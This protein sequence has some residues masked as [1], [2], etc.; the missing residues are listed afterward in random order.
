MANRQAQRIDRARIR[1]IIVDDEPLARQRL[2]S[3]LAAHDDFDLIAEC[4]DG[5]QAVETIRVERPDLVFLDIRMPGLDGFGV[6]DACEAAGVPVP[7]VVFVTAYSEYALR[8]FEVH[9]FD[10]LLKPFDRERFARTLDHV[11]DH[12]RE[13]ETGELPDQLRA[14]VAGMLG[15][16]RRPERFVV[17]TSGKVYFV[18]ADDVDWVEAE[19]NYVRLHVGTTVHLLRETMAGIVTQLDPKRFVRIHRSTIVNL[20]RVKEMQPWFNG[21]YVV[22][23]KDGTRLVMSRGYRQKLPQLFGEAS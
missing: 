16:P 19:G 6:L 12:L 13:R 3:L 14:L 11:R 9:G 8:A 15:E 20:E 1:A 18:K 5:G 22:I 2:R 23:L 10:Y 21:E 17:K 4:N 7:V